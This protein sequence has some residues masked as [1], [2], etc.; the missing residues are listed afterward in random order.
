MPR[1]KLQTSYYGTTAIV[2]IFNIAISL[3][4]FNG[5]FFFFLVLSRLRPTIAEILNAR[6]LQYARRSKREIEKKGELAYPSLTFFFAVTWIEERSTSA[7]I[8]YFFCPAVENAM[9]ETVGHAVIVIGLHL[10]RKSA[11]AFVNGIVADGLGSIENRRDYVY[12]HLGARHHEHLVDS[13]GGRVR[14]VEWIEDEH[15]TRK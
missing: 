4:L 13:A 2:G 3:A 5:R 14:I 1:K 12:V 15:L 7:D 9:I 6:K 11:F 10:M 8:L